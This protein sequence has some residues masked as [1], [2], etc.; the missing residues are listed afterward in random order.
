MGITKDTGGW[1][2]AIAAVQAAAIMAAGYAQIQQIDATNPYS[3]TNLDQSAQYPSVTPYVPQYT[4]NVTGLQETEQLA[5]A[6][7]K[8]NIWVSV[9]DIDSAQKQAQVK[10]AETRF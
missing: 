4:Q 9:K 5:N 10:V 3:N 7:A 2:I 6:L 1:G 8:Q